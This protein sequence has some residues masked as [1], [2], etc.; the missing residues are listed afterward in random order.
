MQL[1][2]ED[3]EN[4]FYKPPVLPVAAKTDVYPRRLSG[5]TVVEAAATATAEQED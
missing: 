1:D 5:E 4:A 2:A 3:D